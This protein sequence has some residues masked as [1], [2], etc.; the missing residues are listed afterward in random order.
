MSVAITL[1]FVVMTDFC[2]WCPIGIMGV[3][4]R[5][6]VKI[7]DD[8]YAWVMV[9]VLPINAAI[10]PFLYTASAVWRKRRKIRPPTA[11]PIKQMLPVI[12]R[13]TTAEN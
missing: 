12:T 1:F 11:P 6:G 5:Y 3:V 10:N 7:P 4:S 8:V 9:F 2:C 13:T